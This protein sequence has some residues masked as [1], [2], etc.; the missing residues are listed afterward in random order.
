MVGTVGSS[1]QFRARFLP[2]KSGFRLIC[3]RL[4]KRSSAASDEEKE[5]ALLVIQK[6]V[7]GHLAKKS[8]PE[9]VDIKGK[10]LFAGWRNFVE[11]F[12]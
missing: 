7:L 5:E 6:R 8:F 12:F 2:K 4:G 9:H 1:N 10:K 3:S 11:V